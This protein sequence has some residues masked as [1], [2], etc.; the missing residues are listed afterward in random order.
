MEEDIFIKKETYIKNN[1]SI[2]KK[3]EEEKEYMKMKKKILIN[4]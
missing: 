2:V 4:K 3:D 1:I